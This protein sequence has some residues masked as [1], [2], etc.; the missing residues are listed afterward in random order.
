MKFIEPRYE[1]KDNLLFWNVI[2]YDNAMWS[3]WEGLGFADYYFVQHKLFKWVKR[4]KCFGYK[5]K[6]HPTY[7]EF[8]KK[9]LNN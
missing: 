9:H 1:H 5:A 2:A 3:K 8:C 6:E 4:I 7:I